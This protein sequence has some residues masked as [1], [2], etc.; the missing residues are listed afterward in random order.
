MDKH[1]NIVS[2][3][4]PW[5][6]DYG[7]VIDVFYRLKAL[8][9][10]GIKIH[11]HCF[12]YGRKKSSELDKLCEEVTYYPR[13]RS[14]FYHFSAKPF[15]VNTRA[16]KALLKNL[17]KNNY[18]ILFEGLH[19]CG[20]LNHPKLVNRLK[21]VRAHNIEHLYY[22][23][24]AKKANSIL[25]KTYYHFEA[26]KLKRFEKTL[27]HASHIAAISDSDKKYFQEK[28]GKTFLLLPGHPNDEIKC[29]TGKG[30]YILYHADL[31]TSENE[32]AA[33]FILDKITPD[34]D[35]PF[36]LAGKNPTAKIFNASQ[37]QSNVLVEA[38]PPFAK[39]EELITNAHI[40]LLPTFQ[41][42]GFKLK[43]LNA[44]YNG[45]FCL[46]TP[47]MAEGTALDELCRI[48]KNADDLKEQIRELITQN[49]SEEETTNRKKLLEKS[50]SNT[51]NIEPLMKV[52]LSD[53]SA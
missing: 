40:N 36:I 32:E 25:K 41:P 15:I 1:L 10:A 2:F 51:Y 8:A 26:L 21:I 48:G 53:L 12:T 14:L 30:N 7:G 17:L 29:K 38:N 35:F 16:S 9:K 46:V 19:T 28:Y 4:V 52:L 39:M 45:R 23:G 44:L 5:P 24:L 20:F 42:T 37:K 33:L 31:S 18:P 22:K 47:Q 49:F 43:L 11:L 50:Y 27:E 34:I 13:P 3:N 6:A